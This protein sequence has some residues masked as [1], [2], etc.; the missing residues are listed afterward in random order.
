[1]VLTGKKK[2]IDEILKKIPRNPL[3]NKAYRNK[4]NLQFDSIGK[5]WGFTQPSFSNGAAYGDLDNDG[6][7][8]LIINNENQEAFIYNNHSN[9]LKK[10]HY[11]GITL[12]GDSLNTFCIGSKIKAYKGKQLFYREVY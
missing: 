2:G 12:Q 9:E 10:S 4:G 6:D 1:M 7:L 11:I 3:L 8:D 5:A